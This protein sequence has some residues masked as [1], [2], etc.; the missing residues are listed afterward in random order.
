MVPVTLVCGALGAGSTTLL[1]Y[2]LTIMMNEDAE[3]D[4]TRQIYASESSEPVGDGTNLSCVPLL[5]FD[6]A[7][8]RQAIINDF[9]AVNIDQ[10]FIQRSSR[11]EQNPSS[12]IQIHEL[13]N[14][15]NYVHYQI[16]I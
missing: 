9:A 14:G 15:C 1:K 13:S 11:K 10:E 7:A 3:A 16:S 6:D 12:D 8:C 2:V 5:M 4:G